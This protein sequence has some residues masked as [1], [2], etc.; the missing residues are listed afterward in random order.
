RSVFHTMR[1]VTALNAIS[2]HRYGTLL[3][4]AVG[5]I[6]ARISSILESKPHIETQALT[7]PLSEVTGD[8]VDVVGG[9]CAN[10]GELRNNAQVLTP[11]GFAITTTAYARFLDADGLR[12]EIMKLLR[13]V[14]PNEPDKIVAV[15]AGI[16]RAISAVR[17]PEAITQALL[18][19]WDSTFA[20]PE[21]VRVA[22]RSSAI[23]EDGVLSFS[24]QYRTVL[25]VQRSNIEDAFRD[26]LASLFSPRAITYRIHHGVPFE[27]CAMGMACIEMVDSVAS[28]IIFSRHPV[29]PLSDEIVLNSIWGLGA[30]AVD[31]IIEPDTWHIKRGASPRITFEHVADKKIRLVSDI[32]GKHEE[33]VPE[34]QRSQPSLTQEQVLTLAHIAMKL[35]AHYHRPQDIEWALDQRGQIVILQSRPMHLV[36]SYYGSLEYI[37]DEGAD[38]LIDKSDIACTGIGIGPAVLASELTDLADFP[39]DG[40][41]VA[42]HSLPNY[43]LVMNR[44]QAVVTEA[45]SITGHMAS[46]AREFNVPTLL[47]A[48]DATSLVK[49]GEILTVDAVRGRIYRGEVAELLELRSQHTTQ[50][51]DTPV[52][53]TLRQVADQIIPLHL[54]D[55]KSELFRPESCTTL[56]DVMRFIH[57]KCY[58]EMFRISDRAS[59]AGAVSTQLKAGLPINLHIIDL[60]GGLKDVDGP[61]VYLDQITSVPLAAMLAGMTRPDVHERGPRPV[62]M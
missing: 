50:I 52:H 45:G 22:V 28:G 57:E 1:M 38:L 46:L 61:Y 31:G 36:S 58:T 3:D 55:P 56:H 12:E 53:A 37:A 15:S 54:L 35:D 8:L 32:H 27:Q 11:E 49:N 4:D 30:Y 48:K 18:T 17:V 41:L 34:A 29:D 62:H 59:D 19:T 16:A 9:K 51:A 24:G 33:A 44:A 26:V 40:I 10:L 47:N 42:P 60:G 6:N 2:D 23:S 43:V 25:G 21:T 14:R 39:Q 20:N 13:D 7:F 5:Y